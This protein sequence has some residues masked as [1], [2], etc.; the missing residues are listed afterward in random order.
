MKIGDK[1][2]VRDNYIEHSWQVPQGEI[3]HIGYEINSAIGMVY[4]LMFENLKTCWFHRLALKDPITK[5][6]IKVGDYVKATGH[7]YRLN[8]SLKRVKV[9]SVSPDG[10]WLGFNIPDSH[11]IEAI[12]NGTQPNYPSEFF[13]V[14]D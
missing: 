1:V 8:D 14:Y 5:Q 12:E 7:T 11:D 6:T 2:F 13:E 10:N 4:L 9:V 3:V